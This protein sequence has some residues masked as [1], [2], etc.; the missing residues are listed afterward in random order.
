MIEIKTVTDLSAAEKLWRQISPRQTVYDDWDFRSAFYPEAPHPLLFIA[1]Y[2]SISAELVGL[3]PLQEHPRYGYEFFA[4]YSSEESRPFVKPGY[5]DLIPQL[6]G[7]I[8]GPGKLSDISGDDPFTKNFLLEDYKYFL[9][10][11]GLS[12]FED[13]LVTRLSPK[14]R[15][16]LAKEIAA[17]ELL[18]PEIYYYQAK[19]GA[20]ALE[21]LFVL[22]I[23]NF[24]EDSYLQEDDRLSWRRLLK[25]PLD[26]R[27]IEI[28]IAGKVIAASLAILYNNTWDYLLTGAAF[29][30]YPG[31]G[32][33]LVKI[34]IEAA[35]ALGAKVFDA[36]LGDC[37]WKHNWHFD[38]K[39]QYELEVKSKK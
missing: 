36:G 4:E 5:E 22:N 24:R 15:R 12:S 26:I 33:Y 6:Y 25:S 19:D 10:L 38:R 39:E 7:A 32:K 23:N 27:L 21:R 34:N 31:L 17:I 2:D 14:R 11:K 8:P 3:L 18:R 35:I 29:K 9:P 20:E 37:G 1:A 30:D 13:F 28:S 16:S